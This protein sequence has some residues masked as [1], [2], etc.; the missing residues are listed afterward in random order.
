V[1]ARA[2][3]RWARDVSDTQDLVQETLLQT[4]KRVETFESRGDGAFQA[5]LRQALLNRIRNELRR[6]RRR[7]EATDLDSKQV[8]GVLRTA[9][10]IRREAVDANEASADL[11]RTTGHLLRVE[12][13]RFRPPPEPPQLVADA[14]EQ[15][16]PQVRLEC[17]IAARFER[18]H[19]LKRL[20]QR[21]LD[22]VLRVRDVARPS[23]KPPARPP[24]QA[25]EIAANK[26][27]TAALSPP[28]ARA[29][30]W[31]VDSA[32]SERGRRRT[33]VRDGSGKSLMIGRLD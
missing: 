33:P 31:T 19:S 27:S 25:W 9:K 4:F 7:P 15:R 18:L 17:A 11:N 16:L 1:G 14:V 20:E 6:F 13:G 22:K 30:S 26:L 10:A 23:G 8:A 3:S 2:A 21:F 32:P 24:P 28:R 5:Y 12:V 29:R